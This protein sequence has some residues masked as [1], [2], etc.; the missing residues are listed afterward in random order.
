[1]ICHAVAFDFL[2]V[3]PLVKLPVPAMKGAIS[4]RSIMA[5]LYPTTNQFLQSTKQLQLTSCNLIMSARII[6][7]TIMT[8]IFEMLKGNIF[9]MIPD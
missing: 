2:V 8:E 5:P 3:L 9:T 6:L 1:M 7:L 4:A